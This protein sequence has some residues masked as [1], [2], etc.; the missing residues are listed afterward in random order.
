M[1]SWAL[2]TLMQHCPELP[3]FSEALGSCFVQ[4]AFPVA[5]RGSSG[6]GS[7][8][9]IPEALEASVPLCLQVD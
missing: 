7:V 2:P 1:L 5:C 6:L 3:D 4:P 8:V 9:P